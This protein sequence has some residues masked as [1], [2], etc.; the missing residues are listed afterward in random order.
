[1]SSTPGRI[2]N[3]A[4]KRT[5]CANCACTWARHVPDPARYPLQRCL[6]GV[7]LLNPR[8]TCACTRYVA[9][10]VTRAKRAK[11]GALR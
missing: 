8:G 6:T 4:S 11:V 10:T 5:Q 9:A 1:M 3:S 7:S 2:T